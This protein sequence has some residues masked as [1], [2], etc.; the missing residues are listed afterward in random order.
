MTERLKE[1]EIIH[2]IQEYMKKFRDKVCYSHH[3]RLICPSR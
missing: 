1:N 3:K 2:V